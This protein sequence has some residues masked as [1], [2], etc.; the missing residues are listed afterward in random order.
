M[1]CEIVSLDTEQVKK[2]TNALEAAYLKSGSDP[3]L[4]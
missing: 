1:S 4:A 2:I 3:K